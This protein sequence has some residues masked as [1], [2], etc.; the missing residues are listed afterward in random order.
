MCWGRRQRAPTR[1]L[2]HRR[3]AVRRHELWGIPRFPNTL[4]NDSV[5]FATLRRR[6]FKWVWRIHKPPG[7]FAQSPASRPARWRRVGEMMTE[8]SS[9]N[10]GYSKARQHDPIMFLPPQ[11][12]LPTSHPSRKQTSPMRP[13]WYR[14]QEDD[15]D[16]IRQGGDLKQTLQLEPPR[17]IDVGNRI[18]QE[19]FR[20]HLR[21]C[22]RLFLLWHW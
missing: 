2:R 11:P 6:N 22:C 20:P 9:L 1:H 14:K 15:R 7:E 18:Q 13:L 5:A 19:F 8:P 16:Y 4:G 21:S 3:G 17:F 12:T 10:W